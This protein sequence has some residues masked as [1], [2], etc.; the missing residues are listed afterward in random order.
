MKDLSVLKKLFL[1]C[2]IFA[3]SYIS[4]E[5]DLENYLTQEKN[6]I[7]NYQE[8]KNQLEMDKLHDSWIS[9]V[10][11][12]YQKNWTTQPLSGTKSSS[13]FSIGIDQPIFRSGGIYYAIKYSDALRGVNSQDIAMK[14]K[15]LIGQAIDM[16]YNIKKL[17]L[18][19][20]KLKLLVRNDTIDIQRKQES[21]GAGI[22]DSSFLD[23]AILKRNQNES[24]MLD[25]EMNLA[26][27]RNSFKLLSR[28][29]PDKLKT[30][31][32]KMIS[33]KY[34]KNNNMDLALKQLKS[35][36]KEYS[37]KM[38]W[39]KYLPTISVNAR[40]TNTDINTPGMD[41]D[42]ST[43]GFKISVPLNINAATDIESSRVSYM[44][45]VTEM[46]DS[47]RTA[48]IEH[49]IVRKSISILN[50]RISLAKKDEALYR[51]LY[52]RTKDLVKAGEKTKQD[53]QTMLN[54]LNIKQLDRKIYDI[55]KQQQ[56][57]KL[58][59]KVSR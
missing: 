59:I 24:Q 30:P 23:Q 22:L 49:S 21:Y 26:K 45:S 16:L 39:A 18:Q 28:K 57:L 58:Y 50:K 52:N 55:E 12:T 5:S 47:R 33:S 9:P 11:V 17:K 43:Y 53:A 44:L 20:Q 13:A 25:I 3:T 1:L 8:M 41:D 54:S 15:Q 46:Q 31:R 32:L 48:G 36:E 34:Y 37:N 35:L 6:L 56:L 10:M 42:Y 4:A 27:L 29:N 2:S 14:K 40:Y 38:T 19:H 7:F 51:R